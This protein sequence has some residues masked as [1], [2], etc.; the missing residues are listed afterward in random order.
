M[1]GFFI[2]DKNPDEAFD[3]KCELHSKKATEAV[4]TEQAKL[5]NEIENTNNVIKS[6]KNTQNETKQK[7]F[8]KLLSLSQA[9][10]VGETAQPD[11]ALNSLTKL[12]EE[13][14]LVEGQ[15]IKNSYMMDLGI[16]ALILSVVAMALAIISIEVSFYSQVSMYLFTA[17]GAF[18]GTWVS[19]GA[20]RFNITFEQLSLLEEDMMS[21]WIRLIYIGVCSSIFL[22]MLNTKI[23]SIGIGTLST[24]TIKDSVELQITVGVLCGLV[25]SKIGLNLYKKATTFISDA[26]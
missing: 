21:P 9:G 6:L 19:F 10:L 14:V 24:T 4:P 16:K 20:R 8:D 12:R 3:I 15:R 17:F 23:L 7:Y 5:Y 1:E 11:L 22:L 25:E 26:V 13:M 2:V 18:V